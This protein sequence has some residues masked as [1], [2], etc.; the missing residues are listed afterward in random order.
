MHIV[1]F[2]SATLIRALAALV[3]LTGLSA[4]AQESAED[5]RELESLGEI[6]TS[7]PNR[8]ENE[9]TSVGKK[10]QKTSEAAAAVFVITQDD[11]RRSGVT[12]IADALRLAPGVQV[13]RVDANHWAISARGFN[14]VFANKLLVLIDGR[15][16]YSPG[17]GGVYWD[18]QDM[19]LEDIHRIEVIRGP[20]ASLWGANAVNGVINIITY[21]SQ[22]T[23]GGS[24]RAGGGNLEQGFGSLRY[25]AKLGENTYGRVFAKGVNRG[26]FDLKGGGDAE[27]HWGM[28]QTGFRLDQDS[29]SG[30]HFMLE[31]GAYQNDYQHLV[32]L[33]SVTS[34]Y[35]IYYKDS[36]RAS[37]F[38]LLGRWRRSLSLSSEISLQAYYDHSYRNE[39]YAKQER[40]TLDLEAQYRF[41]WGDRQD[42]SW[43]LGY[44][45]LKDRVPATPYVSLSPDS[46][47]KQL[48]SAFVQDNIS[49]I[50]RE[51]TLT[52]GAKLQHNDYTG[53]EGQPTI[54][55]LWTPNQTHSFWSAISRAVRT[56]T[57]VECCSTSH[58][59]A[60]APN[61]GLNS[62]PFPVRLGAQP[63]PNFQSE[64]EWAYELGY[65]F[66]VSNTFSF[67]TAFFYNRYASLRA[68]G[69]PSSATL[70]NGYADAQFTTINGTSAE[71][72][73]VELSTDWRPYRWW[74]VQAAYSYLR[75]NFAAKPMSYANDIYANPQQQAYLRSGFNVSHDVDL[76]L[77]LRY[78]D[79]LPGG[80]TLL[81]VANT[82]PPYLTLDVRLAW[83]PIHGVELSLVGQ[84][85]LQSHHLEFVQEG[86][87]APHT[88]VPRS[89]Y[90]QM[91][92][93][94]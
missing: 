80:E 50:D 93:Q 64:R 49:V 14:G 21:S 82:V 35:N 94:F 22:N 68:W 77:W 8:L 89:Y 65:R 42:I 26:S 37:G 40:D 87:G 55:L 45:L 73:G 54:R 20:G 56:P 90:L 39:V 31:G 34:P 67:D 12:S 41:L 92:W 28:T 4:R 30:N 32:S 27:D 52:L 1:G 53:F 33:P 24:F 23:Q 13:G 7:A 9:V 71:A 91:S 78:V 85:L 2:N 81:P 25:G 47:N 72:Y 6:S 3:F 69:F 17:F 10:A 5:V 38:N 16:V 70:K 43:G 61:T 57:R 15:E 79:Q 74:S 66:K 46:V 76:D 11:I 84:N 58:F 51:L 19:P 60:I 86:F 44:R 88:E 36:A 62:S 63:N 59:S 29:E 75:I 48:F 83:R 18:V